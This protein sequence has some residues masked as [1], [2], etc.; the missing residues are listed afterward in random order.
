M[1]TVIENIIFYP[2]YWWILL[3]IKIDDIKKVITTWNRGRWKMKLKMIEKEQ[4]SRSDEIIVIR[5]ILIGALILGI[6]I[7]I[8]IVWSVNALGI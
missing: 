6:M 8:M 7:A 3:M 4:Q 2:S 1:D 5:P